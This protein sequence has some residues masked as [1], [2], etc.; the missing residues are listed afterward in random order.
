ME[1]DTLA[2]EKAGRRKSINRRV[3]ASCV[4]FVVGMVGMSY[5]AVPLYKIFCQVTG[6]GGTTQRADTAPEQAL[7]QE[8]TVRFDANVAPGLPLKF[9]P[10]TTRMKIRI[11]ATNQVNF[12]VTNVDHKAHG[13]MATFNVSP[14]AA[15]AYFNKMECFCFTDQVLA[16]GE[17]RVMPVVFFVDPEYAKDA[18]TKDVGTITLS[19]TFF[20]KEIDKDTLAQL[21]QT[22]QKQIQ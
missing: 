10:E 17:T 21:K 8:M 2:R 13:S 14:P 6:Y 18:D 20:S 12:I 3:A 22:T 4:C 1:N 5:A 15:G 16:P 7:D 19:Y 11:G 9:K